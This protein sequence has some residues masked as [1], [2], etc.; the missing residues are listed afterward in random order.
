MD[1]YILF[2]GR[3][4]DTYLQRGPSIND[5]LSERLSDIAQKHTEEVFKFTCRGLFEKDKLLLALQM[6][7]NL[8]SELKPGIVIDHEEYNFFLRG[9]DNTID[10]KT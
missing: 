3:N 7:I 4:I 2:F 10:R 5:S 8:V 6:A 1:S 9:G